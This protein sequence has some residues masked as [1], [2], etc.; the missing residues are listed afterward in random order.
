MAWH[1]NFG[2]DLITLKER[3]ASPPS[4][5]ALA[6]GAIWLYPQFLWRKHVIRLFSSFQLLLNTLSHWLMVNNR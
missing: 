2:D 6:L 1:T 3:L 5:L 4:F